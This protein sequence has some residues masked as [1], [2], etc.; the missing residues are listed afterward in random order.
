M[1]PFLML[2]IVAFA[3]LMVVFGNDPLKEMKAER[4]KYGRDPLAREIKKF[5]EEREKGGA[6]A[7]YKPPAGAT[8]FRLPPNQ[9][10]LRPAQKMLL[11]G[12]EDVVRPAPEQ[13][14]EEW[15]SDLPSYMM[16]PRGMEGIAQ[17][18]IG[19][20][21][22]PTNTAPV[23]DPGNVVRPRSATSIVPGASQ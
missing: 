4:E 13:P 6:P 1:P 20:A 5:V 8:V 23:A 12:E 10:Q 19:G 9:A 15:G 2:I 14:V 7:Q 3:L 17:P 21:A 11:P 18:T 22:L 16:S